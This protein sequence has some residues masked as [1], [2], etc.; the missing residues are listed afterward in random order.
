MSP[1]RLLQTDKSSFEL[2]AGQT[3]QYLITMPG[4]KEHRVEVRTLP[5]PKIMDGPWTVLFPAGWGA[6]GENHSR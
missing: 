4:R 6:P 5:A 1:Y 3:G 2:Q